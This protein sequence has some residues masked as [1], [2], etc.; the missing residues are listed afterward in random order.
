MVEPV[1]DF[2][3]LLRTQ[4]S[5]GYATLARRCDDVGESEAAGLPSVRSVTDTDVEQLRTFLAGTFPALQN[6]PV[7]ATRRCLYADTPDGD[8]WIDRHPQWAGLTVAGGDSGHAF[9][10]GPVLGELI[11]DVLENKPNPYKQK[12]RWRRPDNSQSRQFDV[13]RFVPNQKSKL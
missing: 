4:S 7:V 11:A 8:F 5:C 9:K 10:F 3:D 2:A 6:A 1:R 13:A 12:F